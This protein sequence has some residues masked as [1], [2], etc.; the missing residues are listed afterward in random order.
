LGDRCA[1]Y[2]RRRPEDTV[3]HKVVR[4]HLET[5]LAELR[6]RGDGDGLP[7]FVEREL[8]EF[9]TCGSMARG[10]ARFRCNGCKREILV[11][12]SCKGRGFCPSC[13][14]R[15]MC[16]LAA[17]L[18]DGVIGDRPVRQWVL[19]LP[20]RL[21]FKL[22]Y[23]H[24]LCRAVLAVFVR[25]L[26]AFERRRA[27]EQG[28]QGRGGAVTS[29]QRCGSALNTNIHFHTLVAEGVFEG[30]PGTSQTFVAAPA[31]PTDVEVGRLLAAVRRRIVRLVRRHGID[32]EAASDDDQSNELLPFDSPALAVLQ[33]AS[34]LGR[35]ATGPR[36]GQRVLRL[37]STANAP[38]VSSSG[39]RHA[40]LNGFD[41]HANVAV[42]AGDRVRLEHLCRYVL[43]PPLA[44]DALELTLDG[45]VLLRLRRPWRDGTCAIRFE[46]SEFLERLAAMVPRPRTNMLIYHGAFAPRG[47]YHENAAIM[48]H[49]GAALSS[50][51]SES[52]A[53]DAQAITASTETAT[54]NAATEATGDAALS[55]SRPAAK[56][57]ARPRHFAWADLL[58]RV[59][60]FDILAC[61]DC[62]GRLRLVATIEDPAVV[63]KILSHLGLPPD[64]PSPSPARSPPW[65]PGLQSVDEYAY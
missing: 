7:R 1:A 6:L 54:A 25:A 11:A 61:A 16:E 46:P 60:L 43:R 29:I 23:D 8:R 53:V 12:F 32:L 52:D 17:H 28:V 57:Y 31:P 51:P 39:P 41:L 55:A 34:V 22:A 24:Q 47:Y 20:H 42:R 40:H 59:F 21:R 9:L 18:V 56:S 3:L 35:V 30:P 37:G 2:V 49:Q 15:R 62:G 58:R 4:Q 33:G 19:T 14:G 50:S 38:V 45:K 36:A 27:R 10:F 65:L 13:C 63:T 26:L 5:F 48:T 64:P 44:Q